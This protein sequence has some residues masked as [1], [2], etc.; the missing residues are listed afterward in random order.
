MEIRT[1]NYLSDQERRVTLPSLITRH[2][3]HSQRNLSCV[4]VS[5]KKNSHTNKQTKNRLY[6]FIVVSQ[7][8]CRNGGKKYSRNS[9][10]LDLL[11]WVALFCIWFVWHKTIYPLRR[12]IYRDRF[13]CSLH[14]FAPHFF[15]FSWLY[16]PF[17]FCS[18][19][20]NNR[21]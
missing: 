15:H 4:Y 13:F 12:R 18:N 2:L 3:L 9:F 17:I 7:E 5:I 11:Q 6:H 8:P 16:F 21:E 14:F 19:N 20:N 10:I 1:E